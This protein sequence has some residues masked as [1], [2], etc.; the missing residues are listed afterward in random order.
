MNKYLIEILKIQSSII[1]PGLGA[2]MVPSQKSGTIVFNQHLKFN[3]GGF[4]RYISEK[5]GIDV[6]EAQNKVAKFIREIEAELGKGN[7]YDMFEFGKFF[8]TGAGEVDFKMYNDKLDNQS[9]REEKPLSPE[10]KKT[11]SIISADIL[12]EHPTLSKSD[13]LKDDEQKLAEKKA[14]EEH[15]QK[16]KKEAEELALAA[17]AKKREE[18]KVAEQKLAEA[19]AK[20]EAEIEAS[21]Q[22][23]E[24]EKEAHLKAA[25]EKVKK[26]AERLKKDAEELAVAKKKSDEEK[27]KISPAASAS[28]ILPSVTEETASNK[29]LETNSTAAQEEKINLD[30]QSKNTYTP[31]VASNPVREEAI[32]EDKAAMATNEKVAAATTLPPPPEL[33]KREKKKRSKLP[34]LILLLL[35]IGLSVSGF[36]YKDQIL[37]YFDKGEHKTENEAATDQNQSDIAEPIADEID[38]T[39]NADMSIDETPVELENE[40]DIEEVVEENTYPIINET[41]AGSYHLIGNSFGEEGNATKYA[42][43]M[44]SKGYPAQIIGR[45]DGLYLVSLRSYDSRAAAEMGRS[46]VVADAGSAWIFKKP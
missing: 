24:V 26:E 14:K 10:K 8:K 21:K 27:A 3:D 20:K 42:E 33:G 12:A 22:K 13:E 16:A 15:E 19:Q 41:K 37:A 36:F 11:A 44:K 9:E 46:S 45:Y 40:Q 4:A 30:K 7:S 6:Q 28:E 32:V 2:L 1:L 23:S 35:L 25:E 34:W 18:E 17:A 29:P 39:N 5:E 38:T 31:P 43:S